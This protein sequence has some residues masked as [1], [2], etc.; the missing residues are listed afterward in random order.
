MGARNF[1]RGLT[2]FNCGEEDTSPCRDSI[3]DLDPVPGADL[4][5]GGRQ[6]TLGLD[7]ER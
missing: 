2:A 4:N 5:D 6:S 1:V 3:L 7:C